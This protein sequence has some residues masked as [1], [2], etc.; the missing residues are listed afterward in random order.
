MDAALHKMHCAVFDVVIVDLLLP[1]PRNNPVENIEA[2][3]Q[4]APGSLVVVVSGYM[5]N[6]EYRRALNDFDV[7]LVEKP[8]PDPD[9][10]RFSS[11]ICKLEATFHTHRL[12]TAQSSNKREQTTDSRRRRLLD[13]LELKPRIFGVGLDLK[14]LFPRKTDRDVDR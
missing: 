4:A 3:K 7:T 1:P 2:V 6:D 8:L 10:E 12:T 9:S 11:L 14:K 5:D 13:A